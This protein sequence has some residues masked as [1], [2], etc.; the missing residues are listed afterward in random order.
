MADCSYCQCCTSGAIPDR[1]RRWPVESASK[2]AFT[3]LLRDRRRDAGRVPED[4]V[5]SG[6][7]MPHVGHG[8]LSAT[9]A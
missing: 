8:I 7:G 5:G 2:P 9:R 1:A 4:P 6:S 3:G